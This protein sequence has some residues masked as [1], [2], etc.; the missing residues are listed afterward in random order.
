MGTTFTTLN[1]YGTERAEVEKLLAPTDMLRD[2]N[3]PWLTVIPAYD[4][5]PGSAKRLA[6][7]ARKLTETGGAA[8]TF[9]YF[10]DDMFACTLYRGGKR[11]AV[12]HSFASFAKL[13]KQLAEL[14]GDDAPKKAFRYAARCDDLEE[15]IALI[16]ETV[17]TELYA[18]QG[19]EPR[20]VPRGSATMCAIKERESRIKK[21]KNLYKLTE[22]PKEDWPDALKYRERILELLKPR[23][24]E[25]DLSSLLY[26]PSSDKYPV[27]C[28]D[29]LVAY[30]YLIDYNLGLSK[31]FLFNGKTGETSEL[32]PFPYWI[33]RA[34]YKTRGGGIVLNIANQDLNPAY[35]LVC[36][37]ETGK[38]LWNCLQSDKAFQFV[39]T[40]ENGVITMFK[41]GN[42]DD[43]SL[44]KQVDGETGRIIRTRSFPSGD[45]VSE[46]VY[47][48]AENAFAL[49]CRS[50]K[51]IVLITEKLEDKMCFGGC[52]SNCRFTEEKLCGSLLWEAVI[53]QYRSVRFFD[54]SN[55]E[56][57]IVDL[58][59]KAIP[60]SVVSDGRI[61]GVNEKGNKLT[62]FDSQGNAAASFGSPGDFRSVFEYGGAVFIE[63]MRGPDTHGFVYKELFDE[64]TSHILRLDSV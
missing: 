12:C 64:T 32:G 11:A 26:A 10:D 28:G 29:G 33:L 15:Q 8:L 45:H 19:D 23:W 14:L 47:V 4:E 58:E 21:R 43:D 24:D 40:S 7:A 54:L 41:S 52:E 34:L 60:I 39:H 48:A 55:G 25:Y 27:P 20:I 22:V 42:A 2:V 36:L 6:A 63:E 3:A 9:D 30:P 46:V 17:G 38:E 1:L 59:T 16:E 49:K 51:E 53:P 35:G 56:E 5:Y 18:L 31:L 37:D 62:V 50:K 13:G 61:F 57:H 44:I